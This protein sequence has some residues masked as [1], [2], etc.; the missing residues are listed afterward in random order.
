MRA[1]PSLS[2]PSPCTRLNDVGALHQAV[3]ERAQ[4]A[5]AR[6]E[7]LVAREPARAG[8][9]R[10]ERREVVRRGGALVMGLVVAVVCLRRA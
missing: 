9:R 1:L 8:A 6:R 2:L 7:A 5:L 10:Q 4:A 3:L